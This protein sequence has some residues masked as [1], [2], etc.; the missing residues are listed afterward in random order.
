M[1]KIRPRTLRLIFFFLSQLE[2]G[3]FL[4]LSFQGDPGLWAHVIPDVV[5][6][7]SFPHPFCH[8]EQGP[9]RKIKQVSLKSLAF[10]QILINSCIY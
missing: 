4:E 1:L 2:K 3:I 6:L 5:S 7:G 9:K 8:W 10:L